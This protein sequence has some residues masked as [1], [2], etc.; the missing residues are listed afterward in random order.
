[1]WIDTLDISVYQNYKEF[2]YNDIELISRDIIDV[3]KRHL[4]ADN[5]VEHTS[6]LETHRLYVNDGVTEWE[7]DVYSNI[8]ILSFTS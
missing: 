7:I 3:Y 4:F 2:S 5:I 6:T 8:G 1:S